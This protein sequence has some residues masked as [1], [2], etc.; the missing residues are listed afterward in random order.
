MFGEDKPN[1]TSI[2]FRWVGSTTNQSFH[3]NLFSRQ[4]S[5]PK[6]LN[7]WGKWQWEMMDHDL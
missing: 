4:I 2:F 3:I 1:L 6:P 5:E 7:P